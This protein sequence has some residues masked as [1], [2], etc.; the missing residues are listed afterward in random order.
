MMKK[1]ILNVTCFVL[2]L[3][4]L[5]NVCLAADV[6]WDGGGT[7][8][9]WLTPENWVGWL[10]PENW[11]GDLLP[12]P[13]DRVL[14]DEP[15]GTILIE[16]GDSVNPRKILGPCNASLGITT[17]TFTGGSLTNTSYWYIGRVPGGTGVLNIIGETA[18]VYTR[19]LSCGDSGGTAIV[20][21]TA[22]TLEVYSDVAGGLSVPLDGSSTGI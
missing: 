10:T 12:N 5:N 22:G 11:V 13:G 18:Y 1:S 16:A 3:G 4:L 17:M 9:R 6:S 19:D 8:D 14:L 15:G 2:L 21:V 7:D 20:N